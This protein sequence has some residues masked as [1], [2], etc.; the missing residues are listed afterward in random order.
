MPFD[1]ICIGT[2]CIYVSLGYSRSSHADPAY[3]FSHADS[4]Y[5]FS[6]ADSAY[7]F[8]QAD[9]AYGFS[10]ADSAYSFRSTSLPAFVLHTVSLPTFFTQ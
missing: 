8:S 4:A 5:V 10:H 2:Q 1:Q 3:V 7:V 6:H 9:S